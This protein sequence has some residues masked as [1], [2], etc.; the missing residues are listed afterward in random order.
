MGGI[1]CM[2]INVLG[3]YLIVLCIVDDT[4]SVLYK[5]IYSAAFNCSHMIHS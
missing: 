2:N 4:H 5:V 3:V 1:K